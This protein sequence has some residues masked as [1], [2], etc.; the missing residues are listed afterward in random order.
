MFSGKKQMRIQ[1]PFDEKHLQ[2][3]GIWEHFCAATCPPMY[4]VFFSDFQNVWIRYWKKNIS[5]SVPGFAA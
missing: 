3:S 5:I 1:G 4:L 2:F